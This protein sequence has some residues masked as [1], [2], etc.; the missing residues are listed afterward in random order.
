MKRKTGIRVLVI[1]SVAVGLLYLLNETAEAARLG[2]GRSFGSK[3][4]YQRSAP[5]PTPS[6]TSPQMSPN[7]PRP[8]PGSPRP[9][10]AAGRHAGRNADG[11]PDRLPAVRRRPRL[12]GPGL[13]DLVLIG[14][15][16]FLLFRFLRARGWPPIR[17]V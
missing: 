5:A 13:M 11:R 15:G 6:P 10:W 12:G 1:L 3:P 4:S 9:R 7:Q 16:L 2:G 8:A 14:G 17:P